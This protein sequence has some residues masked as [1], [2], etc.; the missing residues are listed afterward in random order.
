MVI[1]HFSKVRILLRINNSPLPSLPLSQ[2]NCSNDLW[3]SQSQCRSCF[4]NSILSFIIPYFLVL[5]VLPRPAVKA[6]IGDAFAANEAFL[7]PNL[8]LLNQSDKNS[9]ATGYRSECLCILQR[10]LGARNGQ[11]TLCSRT[12]AGSLRVIIS[13]AWRGAPPVPPPQPAGR[14]EAHF[15]VWTCTLKECSR[16]LALRVFPVSNS[17]DL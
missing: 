8:K 6:P 10:P 3:K 13:I 9:G 1:T 11:P 2:D 14:P 17:T 5:A 12:L 15:L 4:A 16:H 7:L